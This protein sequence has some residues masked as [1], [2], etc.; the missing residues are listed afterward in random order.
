MKKLKKLIC[1]ISAIAVCC[2]VPPLSASAA[3]T[4]YLKGDVNGDG[5]VDIL[6]STC[7]LQYLRGIVGA[8]GVTSERLDLNRDYVIDVKDKEEL[9]KIINHT[10]STSKVKSINTTMTTVQHSKVYSK[11]DAQ[12]G[13]K[14]AD[15]TLNTVDN[16]SSSSALARGIIGTDDRVIDYS[17][18]GVVELSNGATGFVVGA[19]TIVTAAHC[20]NNQKNLTC[21][22]YNTDGN[23]IANYDAVT[24]HLP[25]DFSPFDKTAV[26]DYALITVKENLNT[27]ACFN[28]GI[29]RDG[30]K[31]TSPAKTFFVT[32]YGESGSGSIIVTGGGKLVADENGD[33]LN[34]CT[35]NYD[36]DTMGGTSGAPVYL[37][38]SDGSMTVIAIHKGGGIGNSNCNRGRRIDTDILHFIYN[39][40]N[41]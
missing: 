36:I 10:V 18:S 29:C 20:V 30:I 26:N 16:I 13:K 34:S 5:V 39:N 14:I 15:Y 37:K 1:S 9:L 8:N 3:T 24:Y 2:S 35:V 31:N 32:G 41:L 27:Y 23:E 22:F 21:T 12:T 17:K 25:Y 11:Y 19:H 7:M 33:I 38:N 28:L 4:S 6:D 40:P